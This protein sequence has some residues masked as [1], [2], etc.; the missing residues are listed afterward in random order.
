MTPAG[1]AA[2][3]RYRQGKEKERAREREFLRQVGGYQCMIITMNKTP[4]LAS[5][6][7]QADEVNHRN[8]TLL[9]QHVDHVNTRR[10]RLRAISEIHRRLLET[11]PPPSLV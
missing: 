1:A 11:V 4:V 6:A 2:E 3:L 7:Y 8:L 10:L 5:R 9:S